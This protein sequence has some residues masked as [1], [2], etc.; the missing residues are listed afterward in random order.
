MDGS[1]IENASTTAFTIAQVMARVGL[2]RDSVYRAIREG[3]LPAKKFGKRTLIVGTD[4]EAFL[5]SLPPM[6]A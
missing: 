5:K 6:A 3:Q 4:L 1:V 2:G